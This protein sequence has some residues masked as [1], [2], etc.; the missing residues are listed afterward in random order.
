MASY[1]QVPQ[2][3][4]PC[5]RHDARGF[6]RSRGPPA[7][8]SAGSHRSSFG[9]LRP[10][11]RH[12]WCLPHAGGKFTVPAWHV[13]SHEGQGPRTA[14]RKDFDLF[15]IQCRRPVRA[16]LVSGR[17]RDLSTAGPAT[18]FIGRSGIETFIV[19]PGHSS[20]SGVVTT[21]TRTPILNPA[22]ARS[23]VA[24]RRLVQ[25]RRSRCSSWLRR[26][27]TPFTASRAGVQ[28]LSARQFGGSTR[29]VETV[30][31]DAASEPR[32]DAAA[33]QAHPPHRH[34]HARF[35]ADRLRAPVSCGWLASACRVRRLA[36]EAAGEGYVVRSIE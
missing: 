1:S 13:R 19:A 2:A 8:A 30:H 27:R 16:V 32:C 7:T 24:R 17:H 35:A 6:G 29:T 31:V 21:S 33:A 14:A 5:P 10:Q 12:C 26:H 18:P 15:V 25:A 11:C 3:G 9:W 4:R 23:T 34:G 22:T 36:R 20:G 28:V